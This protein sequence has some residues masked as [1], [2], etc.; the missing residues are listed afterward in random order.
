MVNKHP[1]FAK[2]QKSIEN[3]GY[4]PESAG[5][6]LASSTRKASPKAKKANKKLKKVKGAVKMAKKTVKPTAKTAKSAKGNKKAIKVSIKT[7][8]K[9]VSKSKG[10]DMMNNMQPINYFGKKGG[11]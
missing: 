1:G 3:E 11:K 8:V 10:M 6:I 4:S 7:T 2:V 5:A 9:P